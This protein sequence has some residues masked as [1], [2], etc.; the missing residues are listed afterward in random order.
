MKFSFLVYT[1]SFLLSFL[2]FF[3]SFFIF[4]LFWQVNLVMKLLHE[5]GPFKDG[6]R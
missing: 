2:S 3:L 4:F 6:I 5:S 1:S